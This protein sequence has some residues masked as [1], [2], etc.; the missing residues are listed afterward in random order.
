MSTSAVISAAA[1]SAGHP[2][3]PAVQAR[4]ARTIQ[5]A[6]PI[7]ARAIGR[8]MDVE[9]RIGGHEAK[10]E[11]RIVQLPTLPFDEDPEVEILAFGFLQH[12]TA[13]IRY[14]QPVDAQNELHHRL[15][16]VIED[17]RVERELGREYPG[18]AANLGRLVTKLVKDDTLK[19]PSEDD[20][21]GVKLRRYL[22]YRLRAEVLQQAGL[23]DYAVQAEEQFRKAFPPGACA[24]IGSVIGRV[25]ALGSTQQASDLAGEILSILQ[26]ESKDPPPPPPPPPGVGAD[27]TPDAGG[28]TGVGIGSSPGSDPGSAGAAAGAAEDPHASARA[29]LR[30]MLEAPAPTLGP[31][32]SETLAKALESA[33]LDAAERGGAAGGFG[34]AEEPT[35]P[36]GG[37]PA[38]ILAEVNSQ[39]TALRTR[40]RSYVESVRHT[41]RSFRRHGTSL[42]PQRVVRAMLGD[43]RLFPTKRPGREVNTAVE[44]LCDRSSSMDTRMRIAA[45]STLAAAAGLGAIRGV[46][47]EA[48]VFP[49][50]RAHIEVLS[51]FDRPLR[52]TVTRYAAVRASGGTPMYEALLWGF[53]RLLLRKEP[54]KILV[55]VTDGEPP[56]STYRACQQAIEAAMAGGLE[57][58]G[59][60]IQVPDITDLFP[61]ARS[62]NDVTELAEAMFGFLQGALTGRTTS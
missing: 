30:E 45:R 46:A 17:I 16:N 7:V 1:A 6:L 41:R 11:G 2:P 52:A 13:H 49:G 37:D 54:R 35:T 21:T 44:L 31:E 28:G 36:Q 33:A 10:T 3:A 12:E 24:R 4:L 19:R 53:E 32:L 34:L 55:C 26:E 60:G 43:A 29:A 48:A 15:C 39:S 23:A 18:F 27:G 58:Y 57:V 47:L 5:G 40:L 38:Q 20:P 8:R 56:A 50:H 22:S 62:I 61:I 9:V 59:I 25:P 14:T 51:P 42:A